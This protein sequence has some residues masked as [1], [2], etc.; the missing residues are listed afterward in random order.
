MINSS[1]RKKP[2]DLIDQQAFCAFIGFLFFIKSSK[3]DN[4]MTTVKVLM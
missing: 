3:F 4:L 2:V 1:L